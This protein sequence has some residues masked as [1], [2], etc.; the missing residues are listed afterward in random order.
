M[1]HSTRNGGRGFCSH[2]LGETRLR[3]TAAPR[4]SGF[5]V[6]AHAQQHAHASQPA[7]VSV[8]SK[9][10]SERAALSL[11]CNW[12][13]SCPSSRKTLRWRSA[14]ACTRFVR[15]EEPH[16]GRICARCA[17]F[18]IYYVV[19]IL[20]IENMQTVLNVCIF[21][22]F[23]CVCC[24]C[25]FVGAWFYTQTLYLCVKSRS[26]RDAALTTPHHASIMRQFMRHTRS[27]HKQQQTRAICVH[28]TQSALSVC[29]RMER[30]KR[31]MNSLRHITH[32]HIEYIHV[33]ASH[34]PAREAPGR[35]EIYILF[36]D[37]CTAELA[38]IFML[39]GNCE[40]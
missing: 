8:Q 21:Y 20:S 26:F 5:L 29:H 32:V 17:H 19:K 40:H 39:R 23:A 18:G 12:I 36:T 34:A 25:L 11:N 31:F 3:P 6:C 10:A 14:I 30:L 2:K 1:L 24:A 37:C 38:G 16:T 13:S 9:S 4:V 27:T 22:S 7:S 15:K 28:T 35:E 33:L